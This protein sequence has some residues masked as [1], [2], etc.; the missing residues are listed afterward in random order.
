M[1]VNRVILIGNVGQNPEIKSTQD[2]KKIAKFSIA[3]SESWKDKNSGERKTK[4]EWVNIDAFG[5]IASVIES[6][7]KKGSKVYV[8]GSLQTTNYT[9]ANGVKK[10]ATKVVLQGF[11]STI[12][13]L[14]SKKDGEVSQHAIDK[15]NGYV[16][17]SNYVKEGQDDEIP[18]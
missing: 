2:G 10:F 14:D 4:T 12:Q 11:N 16:P 7:V 8:E 13:L 17:E 1:A 6:Y 3:I 9:D 5:N 18:F 15:G